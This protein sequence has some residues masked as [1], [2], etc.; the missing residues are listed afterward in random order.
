MSRQKEPPVYRQ[1]ADTLTDQ[2]RHD[3]AA[4]DLLPS[5]S[6]LA[7]R[8]GVN[9][10]TVR[11]ALDEL[12]TAGLVT[13]HQGRGTQVVDRRL[14]YRLSAGSK[15]THN[16]AE[17]GMPSETHCLSQNLELPPGAIAQRFAL[18]QQGCLLRVETL[19]YVEGAPLVR[20]S[21]WFDPRRVP[22]WRE[23][24][25]GGSTRAFMDQHYGLRLKR[26]Q[27]RIE[28]LAAGADDSRWLLCAQHAP[29]LQITS[30]NIDSTGALVEVSVSRARADRF[31]YHIDFPDSVKE[32]S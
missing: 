4:G 22:A 12:V 14:D 19:R 6:E 1:L 27:A 28:A 11:R 2:V 26:R 3:F 8:F 7:E 9:R 16:L 17:L 13:R 15:V 29:L 21:H 24:Y 30:D 5:E 23:R 31:S 25:R 32:M 20:I 10:H 18:Q